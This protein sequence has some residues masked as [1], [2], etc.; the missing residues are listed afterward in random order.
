MSQR[1]HFCSGMLCTLGLHTCAGVRA[2][3]LIACGSVYLGGFWKDSSLRF[4]SSC[5]MQL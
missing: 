4:G 1:T 5:E 2:E 3:P